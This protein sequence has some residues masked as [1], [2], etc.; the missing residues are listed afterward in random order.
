MFIYIAWGAANAFKVTLRPR[1]PYGPLGLSE[2][3]SP[4]RPPRLSTQPLRSVYQVRDSVPVAPAI[5]TLNLRQL[6]FKATSGQ[7][8]PQTTNYKATS[9]QVTP[10]TTNY[11]ATSSQLTPQATNHRDC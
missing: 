8:T 4:G 10:Q 11:K 5:L 7:V 9:S 1:R 3:G 6:E 2:T